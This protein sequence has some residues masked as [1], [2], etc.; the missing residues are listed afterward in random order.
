MDAART[1]S[2]GCGKAGHPASGPVGSGSGASLAVSAPGIDLQL[3]VAMC[4]S[5]PDVRGPGRGC[6][7]L[8]EMRLGWSG[9]VEPDEGSGRSCGGP[10][11][12]GGDDEAVPLALVGEPVDIGSIRQAHPPVQIS[13][14]VRGGCLPGVRARA[15][16]SPGD[17]A[18]PG[19]ARAGCAGACATPVGDDIEGR[20]PEQAADVHRLGNLGR[21]ACARGQ[22][23]G[24]RPRLP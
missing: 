3:R 22:G 10:F 12:P 13:R 23:P 17:R 4:V 2:R 14:S 8:P 16:S 7:H 6:T 19:A 1:W 20:G 21:P 18:G 11:A 24:P 15:G 9:V 5:Q